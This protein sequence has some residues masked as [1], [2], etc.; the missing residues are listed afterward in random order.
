M[1]FLLPARLAGTL[2]EH[3]DV[4]YLARVF[5]II[6]LSQ[7]CNRGQN[8]LMGPIVFPF[9]QITSDLSLNLSME[10]TMKYLSSFGQRL[11]WFL[12]RKSKFVILSHKGIDI[13][14]NLL[15]TQ[16]KQ[17]SFTHVLKL[18]NYLMSLLRPLAC[19]DVLKQVG[20]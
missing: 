15:L 4:P 13:K 11:I 17:K 3:L 18:H 1:L 19:R 16:R 10:Y 12:S 14:K 6:S 20:W 8:Y 5:V 7:S 9:L 2:Q